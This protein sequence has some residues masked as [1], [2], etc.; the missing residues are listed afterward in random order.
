ME[1][2][3][4]ARSN[5]DSL[6]NSQPT[7]PPRGLV[8]TPTGD[9]NPITKANEVKLAENA[10]PTH[11]RTADGIDLGQQDPTPEPQ[12]HMPAVDEQAIKAREERVAERE[13]ALDR[14]QPRE[15]EHLNDRVVEGQIV[16]EY[17]LRA[18][19][20]FRDQVNIDAN[21]QRA[22]RSTTLY[23]M[24]LRNGFPIIGSSV[25]AAPDNYDPN[26]GRKLARADAMQKLW[27]VEEYALRNRLAG[28]DYVPSGDERRRLEEQRRAVA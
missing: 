9:D 5:I 16:A 26:E 11:N 19:D 15:I 12:S 10:P 21:A 25:A 27:M 22:L 2:P 23:V 28:I 7:P 20:A 3:M 24:V 6:P 18:W 8:D 17:S 13:R 14:R 1:V 4:E